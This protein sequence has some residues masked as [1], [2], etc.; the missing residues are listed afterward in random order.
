MREILRVPN[1]IL[2]QNCEPVTVFGPEVRSLVQDMA[3][4]MYAHRNDEIAPIGL[5]APQ[6]G[7]SIRVIV[8]YPN[9][10]FRE[11]GAIQEFINPTILH[12]KELVVRRCTETCMSIPGKEFVLMRYSLVKV[13]GRT[14]DGRSRTFK[15]RGLF[16]QLLQHEINHLDGVMID[17]IGRLVVH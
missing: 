8:F 6:F 12:A 5:S 13:Q 14:C 17:S 4:Y 3:D 9:P 11:R 1:P 2:R 7:E 16:A 15:A 10:E